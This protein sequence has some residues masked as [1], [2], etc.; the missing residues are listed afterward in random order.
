[1]ARRLEPRVL[2]GA[3]LTA[4]PKVR[5]LRTEPGREG[6][7]RR[8]PARVSAQVGRLVEQVARVRELR[9][10]AWGRVVPAVAQV[11]LEACAPLVARACAPRVRDPWHRALEPSRA[12]LMATTGPLRA[13]VG[14]VEHPAPGALL[15]VLADPAVPEAREAGAAVG[16]ARADLAAVRRAGKSWRRKRRLRMCRRSLPCPRER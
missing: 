5:A 7:F 2:V 11:H 16:R 3:V 12:A 1:M 14:S 8:V 15:A 4:A 10:Q 13:E 9:V 6:H